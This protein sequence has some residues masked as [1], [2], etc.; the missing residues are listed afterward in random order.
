MKA[1]VIAFA[2]VA[3]LAAALVLLRPSPRSGPEPIRY[4]RDACARCRMLLSEP[5]FAG[6]IR[7]ARGALTRYDDVGCLVRALRETRIQT[8][9]AWIEDHQAGQLVPLLTAT[10]VAGERVRTPMGYGI[11]AFADAQAARAFAAAHGARVVPIEE[12]LRNPDHSARD[13]AGTHEE[14]SAL[15]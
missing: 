13:H 6:E 3:A 14:G 5:G 10:L 7:D 2:A 9:E 11:V 8:P 4:G 1:A 15:R 12:L